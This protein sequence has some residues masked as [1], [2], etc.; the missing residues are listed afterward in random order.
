MH[1]HG[2]QAECK[3][4]GLHQHTGGA[5]SGGVGA[6]GAATRGASSRGVGGG[7][8][9]TGD[10]HTGDGGAEGADAGGSGTEETG[11]GGSPPPR[12]YTRLQALRRLER[13][14]EE[15]LEQE[16]QQL[17]RHTPPEFVLPSPPASSLTVSSHPI[18]DY[19]H[20]AHLV[21]SRVLASLVTDPRASPSSVSA[22]TGIVTEFVSTRRLD[23]ATRVVAAPSAQPEVARGGFALGCD[24]LEDRQFELGFLT[25]TSPSLYASCYPLKER[26]RHP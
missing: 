4:V 11:A 6:G 26:P 23:F 12:Y 3:T 17:F 7:G 10:A 2:Q 18:T 15:R 9:G 16:R 1:A 24:V 20:T 19:Y 5:S 25:A 14:E 13:E 21:V 22:L 8:T